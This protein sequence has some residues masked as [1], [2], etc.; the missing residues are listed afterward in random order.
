MREM[1]MIRRAY[2]EWFIEDDGMK[3]KQRFRD[4]SR[5]AS[6][7]TDDPGCIPKYFIPMIREDNEQLDSRF[8]QAGRKTAEYKE[9]RKA[10]FIRDGFTCQLCGKVGGTLNAHHIKP[11]ARYPE[12]RFVVDN[13][14]TL[15]Q[16]CHKE[17][18]RRAC[19]H[20]G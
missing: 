7:E 18:H 16:S 20:E 4:F 14:I 5:Y 1:I 11:Y 12:L 19:N 3:A 6:G 13:G 8:R 2:L 17:L 9:W 15:C 10:V